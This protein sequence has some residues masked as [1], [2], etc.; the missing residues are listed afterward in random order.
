MDPT[1]ITHSTATFFAS[2]HLL[3]LLCLPILYFLSHALYQLFLSP[4]RDIPGPWYAAISDFW[5]TTHIARLQQCRAV[6]QLFET[7]GPIVRI[8]PYKVAFCDV[9]GAR[10]VYSVKRFDKTAFYKGF[11]TNDHDH[12]MTILPKD[13]HGRHKKAFAP[14]YT[15][16]SLTQFAP[17]MNQSVREL[18][19]IL[20]ELA[21][22]TSVDC[23]DLFRQ[24]LVDIMSATSFGTKG[25][26]LAAWSRALDQKIDAA[27][28]DSNPLSTAIRDFPKRSIL[29]VSAKVNETRTQI[30]AGSAA[31]D[32]D[33]ENVEGRKKSMI[34][35]LLGGTGTDAK[36]HAELSDKDIISETMGH[37]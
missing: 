8:G 30:L 19:T 35:R 37:L 23:L 25:S 11:Q 4:L 6:H 33:G 22:R 32:A 12:S 10:S 3:T 1:T 13:L 21:G 31:V 36:G 24:L 15:M 17:E 9:A 2:L 29:Y 34:A 28:A 27:A 20:D 18:T 7:Y 5:L 14:H 16:P 26:A